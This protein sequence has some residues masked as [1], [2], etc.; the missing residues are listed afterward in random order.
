MKRIF[1]IIIILVV[2]TSLNAQNRWN[3][4]NNNTIRRE[5]SDSNIPHY[6]HIEMSGQQISAVIRWGVDEK[7]AFFEERS[8]VFPMLRTIPN[9]THASL[10]QRV[11]TD[12]L[13]LISING[14]TLQDEKVDYVELNGTMTVRSRYSTQKEGATRLRRDADITMTRILFPSTDKA[15]FCERYTIQNTD[16]QK[17]INIIIPDFYQELK[18]PANQGV[19]GSYLIVGKTDING[20]YTL[21]PQE[22]LTFHVFFTAFRE[23]EEPISAEGNEEYQKRMS[24]VQDSFVN[25][26][27]LSTPD[28]AIN[29]EFA[30]AKIRAAESIYKTKACR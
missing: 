6:D 8:L 7:G 19:T 25:S 14:L 18:T 12:I 29:T 30:F 1:F 5:I 22:E 21:K 28:E 24:L 26:L 17:T 10:M 11:A 3:I 23:G 27:I 13:R 20:S 16:S 15:L 2:A 9:N 4:L